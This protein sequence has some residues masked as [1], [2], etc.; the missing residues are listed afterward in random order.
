METSL[1]RE[2]VVRLAHS[3]VFGNSGMQREAARKALPP[4]MPIHLANISHRLGR[5][6][7]FDAATMS[8]KNDPEAN[9]MFTPA[10]RPPFVVPERV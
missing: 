3:D 8:C 9:R 6:L 10:Y 2:E 1:I 5:T 7:H 4:V